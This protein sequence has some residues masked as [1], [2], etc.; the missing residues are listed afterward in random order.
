MGTAG[1]I[2]SL[3]T[4]A[5]TVWYIRQ[6]WGC[7]MYLEINFL[8][9]F[10]VFCLAPVKMSKWASKATAFYWGVLLFLAGVTGMHLQRCVSEVGM[11][12]KMS[13]PQYHRGTWHFSGKCEAPYC[14][15]EQLMSQVEQF[16]RPTRMRAGRR[17]CG[18][19]LWRGSVMAEHLSACTEMFALPVGSKIFR[20]N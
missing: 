20:L 3:W 2:Q 14:H 9:G 8:W 13:F 18:I 5:Y 1:A 6:L 7:W 11:I 17:R 10:Y 16:A 4:V 19:V 15:Q 12:F